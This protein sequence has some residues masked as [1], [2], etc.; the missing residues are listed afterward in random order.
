MFLIFII[1]CIAYAAEEKYF[2]IVNPFVLF[3]ALFDYIK[4]TIDSYFVSKDLA[5]K[6]KELKENVVSKSEELL[7]K[8]QNQKLVLRCIQD[9]IIDNREK[10]LFISKAVRNKFLDNDCVYYKELEQV[11]NSFGEE[12]WKCLNMPKILKFVP[13]RM[14]RL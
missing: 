4:D 13:L 9:V 7:A 10:S 1:Y 14:R 6:N 11:K 2:V 3:L 8:E 5:Q 12:M